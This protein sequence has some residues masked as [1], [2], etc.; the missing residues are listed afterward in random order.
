LKAKGHRELGGERAQRVGEERRHGCYS[1][2]E[3]LFKGR[4][5]RS[6]LET[7]REA[8]PD[9]HQCTKPLARGPGPTSHTLR[10]SASVC[11]EGEPP[12]EEHATASGSAPLH[13]HQK[14]RTSLWHG[15]P[16]PR[17]IL[18]G[19]CLPCA[20][21]ANRRAR[22]TPPP[23]VVRLFTSAESSRPTSGTGARAHESY[24]SGVGFHVQRRGIA[25][26]GACHRL[27]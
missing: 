27:R 26:W 22:S 5:P 2:D 4:L 14:Q 7:P 20:E 6:R 24:S 13:L 12:R 9:A 19:H 3:P 16:G 11:G 17:V 21:K 8:S 25:A 10:A 1:R 18:F 15:G 23:P